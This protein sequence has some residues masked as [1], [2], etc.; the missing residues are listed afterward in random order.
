MKVKVTLP[1]ESRREIYR[2]YTQERLSCAEIAR[3]TQVPYSL[4]YGICKN[5]R[6]MLSN[7]EVSPFGAVPAYRETAEQLVERINRLHEL[8]VGDGITLVKCLSGQ[9]VETV[10]T[11]QRHRPQTSKV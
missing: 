8:V 4:V 6:R 11:R 9:E 5:P 1:F 7:Q 2:L 3:R 10:G